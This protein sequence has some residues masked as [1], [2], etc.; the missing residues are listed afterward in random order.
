MGARITDG[1]TVFALYDSVSGYSLSHPIFTGGDFDSD[2]D[3]P[4]YLNGM[5]YLG[6]HIAE[7]FLIWLHR[8]DGRDARLLSSGTD[9]SELS[10]LIYQHGML[11]RKH[12]PFE[13]NEERWAEAPAA[14]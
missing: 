10:Q 11:F 1:D 4:G 12:G 13:H 6:E 2:C 9:N 5:G 7:D 3:D 8:T 14:T